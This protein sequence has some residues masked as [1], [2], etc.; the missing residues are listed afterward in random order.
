MNVKKITLPLAPEAI[1]TL[2]AG[3][4]VELTGTVY[5]ARDAA[6]ARLCRML[7][8]G[9]PLPIDLDGICFYYA[10][11]CPAAP[12]E[13]LGPCG[14]T[15]SSR[16]DAYTPRLIGLG[17]SAMIGKGKR[18]AAVTEAMRG[19]A[20]YFAAPGGAGYLIARCIRSAEVAA[21]DDLG[22]EAIRRLYVEDLP[23]VV[24]IDAFGGDLY[25]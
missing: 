11:P 18:D 17:L 5:T 19:R 6:H 21:F 14:P 24:A 12:G 9:Q 4:M 22:T 10:G 25:R 13:V 3:D 2:R 15:T 7:D 20:V 8:A 16:M 1:K 23:A